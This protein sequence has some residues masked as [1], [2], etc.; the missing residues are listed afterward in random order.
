V[1]TSVYLPDDLADEAKRCGVSVSRV[2]QAAIR[3]EIAKVRDRRE[4]GQTLTAAIW[5]LVRR[6]ESDQYSDADLRLADDIASWYAARRVAGVEGGPP[7]VTVPRMPPAGRGSY[8]VS[9][10]MV[11]PPLDAPPP[12]PRVSGYCD[13]A[14]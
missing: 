10:A 5:A 13:E 7:S 4:Q 6:L 2:A 11:P 8:L 14:P 1:K 3:A 9:T 12:P